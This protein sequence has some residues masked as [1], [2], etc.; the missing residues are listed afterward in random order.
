MTTTYYKDGDRTVYLGFD[1]DEKPIFI[2]KYSDFLT[3][4]NLF[5]YRLEHRSERAHV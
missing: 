1:S 4:F 2:M 3:A 5:K